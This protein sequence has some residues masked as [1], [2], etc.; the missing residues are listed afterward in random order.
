ML[1]KDRSFRNLQCHSRESGNLLN[2]FRIKCGMT[3]VQG[4]YHT[5]LYIKPQDFNSFSIRLKKNLDKDKSL[6]KKLSADKFPR[7][8][9]CGSHLYIL[10]IRQNSLPGIYLVDLGTDQLPCNWPP[11]CRKPSFYSDRKELLSREKIN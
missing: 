10:K 3:N 9:C 2:R 1:S 11:Y 4:F 7:R 8:H 5:C 6:R